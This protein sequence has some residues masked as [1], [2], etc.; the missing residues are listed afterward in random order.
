[1]VEHREPT[2]YLQSW[3]SLALYPTY[4]V[5]SLTEDELT[6]GRELQSVYEL[7]PF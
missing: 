1:M 6:P 5:L 4:E 2:T 7:Y 3:V